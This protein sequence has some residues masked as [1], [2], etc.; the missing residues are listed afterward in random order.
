MKILVM[1]ESC[2]DI[3]V[4]GNCDR[5]EPTAPAPVFNETK[6]LENG[7][8]AKNVQSNLQ[9][10]NCQ[11]DLFTNTNWQD[12]QK[13]RFIDYKTNHMIMRLDKC[14]KKY[15]PAGSKVKSIKY[16]NYDAIIISDYNKGFLTEKDIEYVSNMHDYVF[17]DT[18]KILGQWCNKIKFIKINQHEYNLS[19]N[20]LDAK[21]EN[22]LVVTLGPQGARH[23]NVIYPV[24]EVEIKDL[25]GAG[26]TF[27][28]A[29]ALKYVQTKS[30]ESSISYANECATIVV[31]KR[32][33]STV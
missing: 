11:T 14:D 1:G 32:G 6:R 17:L 27:I 28:S 4:Y 18:K 7:G 8:M 29:L 9:N 20:N 2:R 30:I 3:F 26:D 10:M 5:L 19:V 21:I 31:Q 25:S 16:Q 24:Q 23:N 22:K 13:I 33:V 15:K 12:I